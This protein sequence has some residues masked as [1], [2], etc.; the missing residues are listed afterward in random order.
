MH[1][2]A[3]KIIASAMS[4][5]SWISPKSS[6]LFV[7]VWFTVKHVFFI[8]PLFREFH[9]LGEFANTG[10]WICIFGVLLSTASKKRE[11]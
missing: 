1:V 6:Q 4:K 3:D 2:A 11:N 10:A 7:F 8:C 5:V 9:D